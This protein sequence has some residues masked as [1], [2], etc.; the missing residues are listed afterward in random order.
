MTTVCPW[1]FKH[2][3]PKVWRPDMQYF[4]KVP[5]A[6][7]VLPSSLQFPLGSQR[8]KLPV[9]EMGDLR[10]PLSKLVLKPRGL[11]ELGSSHSSTLLWEVW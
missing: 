6:R 5:E 11:G 10:I 3:N 2:N 1:D 8:I 9:N 4:E 7:S